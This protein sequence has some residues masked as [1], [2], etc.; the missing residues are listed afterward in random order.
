MQL[1]DE[2]GGRRFSIKEVSQLVGAHPYTLQV[3]YD[4]PDEDKIQEKYQKCYLE[5]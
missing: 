2:R 1:L 4:H 3:Y 5:H